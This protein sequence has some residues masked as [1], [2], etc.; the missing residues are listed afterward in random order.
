[1]AWIADHALQRRIT[2]ANGR[3]SVAVAEQAD[4]LAH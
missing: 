2:E 1:M 4:R 3:D